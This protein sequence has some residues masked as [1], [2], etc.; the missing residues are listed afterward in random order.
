MPTTIRHFKKASN[1][2]ERSQEKHKK[3]IWM[4]EVDQSRRYSIQII[5]IPEKEYRKTG[6]SMKWFKNFLRT[7][8]H[9]FQ[10]EGACW[11][12]STVNQNRPTPA[13]FFK[14]N[15]ITLAMKRKL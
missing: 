7:G 4:E 1:L 9:E 6:K 13:H 8:G 14:C 12:P 2:K 5:G 3:G 10:I 15:Y 11:V